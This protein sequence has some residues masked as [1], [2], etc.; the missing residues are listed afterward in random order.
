MK[1]Q[2]LR[3]KSLLVGNVEVST[4]FGN[5]YVQNTF[6]RYSLL[7]GIIHRTIIQM[8]ILHKQLCL[9]CEGLRTKV[10]ICTADVVK[11]ALRTGSYTHNNSSFLPSPP[12]KKLFARKWCALSIPDS[13]SIPQEAQRSAGTETFKNAIERI[14][15]YLGNIRSRMR[16]TVTDVCVCTYGAV[17]I[18]VI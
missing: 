18:T 17:V 2:V 4:K 3:V 10:T 11:R 5:K 12:F 13:Y 9:P 14:S 16:C 7:Y 1:M 8:I 6:V 15:S